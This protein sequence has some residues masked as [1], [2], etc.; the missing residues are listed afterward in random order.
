[1][2]VQVEYELVRN[3]GLRTEKKRVYRAHRVF[4]LWWSTVGVF[5]DV[6]RFV[7][8]V[9]RRHDVSPEDSMLSKRADA[10]VSVT[11]QDGSVMDFSM[12]GVTFGELAD[13][14]EGIDNERRGA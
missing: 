5:K 1:M 14:V 3:R 13:R 8:K 2:P 4:G 7:K 6:S 11:M 10:G 12:P 9:E